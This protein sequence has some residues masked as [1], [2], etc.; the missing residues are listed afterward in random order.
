MTYVLTK[1]EYDEG[2][3]L[4]SGCIKLKLTGF[5]DALFPHDMDYSHLIYLDCSENAFTD[6]PSGM[7]HLIKLN[8]S[9]NK[10]ESLPEDM[11]NLTYL[12]CNENA[13]TYIP[14]G[15]TRMM[16]L[17]CDKN[18]LT[19]LPDDMPHLNILSCYKN[20]LTYIPEEMAHLTHLTCDKNQLVSLPKSMPYVKILQCSNN[21]LTALP[22]GMS[23]LQFLQCANNNL[24]QFPEDMNTIDVH[25]FHCE[26][27]Y[28]MSLP[29]NLHQTYARQLLY[30]YQILP[31]DTLPVVSLNKSECSICMNE[32]CADIVLQCNHM[33]CK[34]C[35]TQWYIKNTKFTCPQCRQIIDITKA[36]QIR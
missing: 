35:I 8:C 28:I 11:G 27:N 9:Y 30:Q 23:K 14:L 19:V 26:H 32:Q 29:S 16:T 2:F 25:S 17:K 34:L 22:K 21:H 1:Q 3:R 6:L 33:L 4:P 5:E 15:M 36:K 12:D 10:L 13:L 20:Q 18:A 24:V 7:F 31:F